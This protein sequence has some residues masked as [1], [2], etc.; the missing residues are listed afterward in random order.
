MP[1]STYSTAEVDQKIAD[2]LATMNA[3]YTKAMAAIAA[4]PAPA[5]GLTA[6]QVQAIVASEV[7][8]AIAALPAAAGITLAQVQSVVD[9]AITKAVATII[10]RTYIGPTMPPDAPPGSILLVPK[11]A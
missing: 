1:Q 10:P 6:A 11:N 8:K 9:A 3:A 5:P 4:I 7:A 2:A